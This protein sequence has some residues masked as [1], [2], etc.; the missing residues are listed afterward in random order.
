MCKKKT[1]DEAVGGGVARRQALLLQRP[2][3]W[4]SAARCRPPARRKRRLLMTA[5]EPVA[6]GSLHPSKLAP[7]ASPA[8]CP[9]PSVSESAALKATGASCQLPITTGPAPG[10]VYLGNLFRLNCLSWQSFFEFQFGRRRINKLQADRQSSTSL[11]RNLSLGLYTP[12]ISA[13]DSRRC[14][15]GRSGLVQLGLTKI[16]NLTVKSVVHGSTNPLR[17]YVTSVDV[18]WVCQRGHEDSV[19]WENTL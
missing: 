13:C 15:W 4:C 19:F 10:W 5:H 17:I 8:S 11:T 16:C 12:T 18:C 2:G 9:L 7:R 6:L 14:C 1:F 3:L